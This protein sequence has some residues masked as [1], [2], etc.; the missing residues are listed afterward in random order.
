MQC[1]P[2]IGGSKRARSRSLDVD[3]D[4]ENAG[5]FD[6]LEDVP[7]TPGTSPRPPSS[8]DGRTSPRAGKIFPRAMSWGS[9]W[10]KS[11]KKGRRAGD[12]PRSDDG[13]EAIVLDD[14]LLQT[15]SPKKKPPPPPPR[16]AKAARA[17]SEYS[18]ASA[19][20]AAAADVDA[21]TAASLAPEP[22]PTPS[23]SSADDDDDA[24]KSTS[25]PPTPPE[26]ERAGESKKDAAKRRKAQ[27]KEDARVAKAAAKEAKK[28]SRDAEIET[29]EL[30]MRAAKEHGE[31]ARVLEESR[32][33]ARA[34]LPMRGRVDSDATAACVLVT[35]PT[36]RRGPPR[37]ARRGD[38]VTRQLSGSMGEDGEKVEAV[39]EEEEEAATTSAA[40][41]G[42]GE[43][44]RVELR[45]SARAS[46]AAAARVRAMVFFASLDQRGAGGDRACSMCCIA[47][48]EW[49]ENNP[50]RLPTESLDLMDEEE[51]EEE[52]EE[53][54]GENENDAS[55]AT[56]P[57]TTPK[58][59]IMDTKL[60][61]EL[62]SLAMRSPKLASLALRSIEENAAATP[63]SP[64][65]PV[66]DAPAPTLVI[67]GVISG[68]AREWR[69]LC[70]DDALARA[71]PDKHFDLDTAVRSHAP[72]DA[73][74][75]ARAARAGIA[76][77]RRCVL[78]TGPHTTPLAW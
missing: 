37:G 42:T 24:T 51:E 32:R 33:S 65:T 23:R 69:A 4:D 30:R 62:A 16:K 78:Y 49:L 63:R 39:E 6:A 44:L 56:T 74:D 3:R 53:G 66:R 2:C 38:G 19:T 7:G 58:K 35:P 36:R 48:A 61:A 70:A 18:S 54:A 22:P 9:L 68:A 29:R 31:L 75:A 28:A 11:P 1:L 43:W 34:S 12:R 52:G 17:A 25:R 50:G 46:A 20:A 27:K 71:F 13:D 45:G 47:L 64:T 26:E 72:F 10:G 76:A 15:P 14:M 57:P 60:R 21:A 77:A 67:D 55:D 8:P 41:A 59:N 73:R 40:V 5:G